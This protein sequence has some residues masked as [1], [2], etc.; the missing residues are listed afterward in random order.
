[1]IVGPSKGMTFLTKIEN[2][3]CNALVDREPS[4]S[5]IS[6]SFY[7][8]L[9]LPPF[10]ELCRTN[11]RSATGSNLTPLGIV[12]CSFVLGPESFSTK[13]IVCKHL[14]RALIFG[15]DFL[16]RNQ[17]GIY[18]SKLG[19]CI[20]EC[21]QQE[22]VFLIELESNPALIT[23]KQ[24]I[25]PTRTLAVLN[26]RSTVNCYHTGK[27]YDIWV[28]PLVNEQYPNLSNISTP[29]RIKCEIPS[30]VPFVVINLS[31][32]LVTIEKKTSFSFSSP[33]RNRYQWN[34]YRNCPNVR[35]RWL[36]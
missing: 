16:Q 10:K 32:A 4:K 30:V 33:P 1:M 31:Y 27:L 23:R 5:C 28:N 35:V 18:Y 20:L 36:W 14:I 21:E 15:E 6:E 11:V 19:K 3:I 17:I 8:Q 25:I 29:H 12:T 26:V 7:R 2:I 34:K 9:N 24:V 13:M 22:L